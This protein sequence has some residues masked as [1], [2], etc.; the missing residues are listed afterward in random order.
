[1]PKVARMTYSSSLN[2]LC[3]VNSSFDTGI[4]RI[5]YTGKNRNGSHI[6]KEVFEKCI[7]TMYNCPIVCNYDREIDDLG[8]HDLEVV[9]DSKGNLKLINATVPVGVVPE[10]SKYF[11][12]IVEENDG[13]TKEYLCTD[14]LIWKRQEAYEKLKNDGI[15]AQSMEITIK[16]GE[17]IDGVYTIY[18]FEFTAF[19]LLG[20][21]HEPCFESAALSL[22]S[23]DEF[24]SQMAEMMSELR[25]T[26]T[27]TTP[28]L[29]DG[30]KH[31][32]NL[33]KKGDEKVLDEK[34]ALVA[35][36]GL[37]IDDLDFSLEDITIEEL[38]EKFEAMKANEP[39]VDDPTQYTAL[40]ALSGQIDEE[41]HRALRAV[42]VERPWG[43]APRYC[44]FDYD[45]A[46]MEL[47]CHD[48]EDDWKLYGFKFAMNGDRV[49]IDFES[50]KRMKFAVVE[51]DEGE[52][53]IPFAD[54]FVNIV[55]R[56]T[57]NDTQWSEKYQ[58]ISDTVVSME[59]ELGE[60]R[61]F[62][63][64]TVKAAK[65]AEREEVFAQFEDLV[66]VEEFE[67]L[68]ENCEDMDMDALQE[69]CFAIRGKRAVFTKAS[70]PRSPKF[71]VDKAKNQESS[72]YGDL[73]TKYPVSHL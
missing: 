44:M 66:G 43:E 64:D 27:L 22:F 55:D 2:S 48:L 31:P 61:Q 20:E 69:K 50:K 21:D 34:I 11:W 42:T 52:Q 47:Y 58:A 8:G 36:Y 13:S 46:L 40:Y 41:I 32:L 28:S 59:S 70:E 15:V 72:P 71:V 1:M 45:I 10:S 37:N 51:F 35:E 30:N 68:K 24:K 18:D 16:D 17:M 29:E 4:L 6:S 38:R 7:Q 33:Q 3:E 73:F 56:A 39:A 57:A 62:K 60:L 63:T 67:V 26:F 14:V 5:A 23:Y 65:D 53:A 49:E 54:V 12:D 9:R 25:K 19:C